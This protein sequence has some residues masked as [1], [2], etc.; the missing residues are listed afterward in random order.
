M[1][2]IS[3]NETEVRSYLP[4][5]WHL[6]WDGGR[7]DEK[8]D[9]WKTSVIDNVDFDWQLEVKASDAAKHGR[10]EALRQ[11][12]DRTYRQRYT[13]STSGLGIWREGKAV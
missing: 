4:N 3:Y 12:I 8:A 13:K 10:M 1:S 2:E 7:W 11:A 9:T 5:G 6:R